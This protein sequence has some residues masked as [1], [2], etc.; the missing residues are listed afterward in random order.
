MLPRR[1]GKTLQVWRGE[2][3]A[4]AHL[5]LG[6]VQR[7]RARNPFGGQIT[8][9]RNTGCS[10][11]GR[12]DTACPVVPCLSEPPSP[13]QLPAA[14]ALRAPA[15]IYRRDGPRQGG[16]GPAGT[17]PSLHRDG[18]GRALR[19]VRPG[20]AGAWR[21]RSSGL[22]RRVPRRETPRW[23][24][25][26][27]GA[28]PESHGWSQPPRG[29]SDWPEKYWGHMPG[30]FFFFGYLILLVF[31]NSVPMSLVRLHG[32]CWRFWKRKGSS[33]AWWKVVEDGHEV[34]N[35]PAFKQ[36]EN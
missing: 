24:G 22:A 21:D 3:F 16:L 19:L 30:F 17:G 10:V 26:V 18:L 6:S 36:L 33:P 20:R 35:G 32:A 34:L 12:G 8:S 2:G 29:G 14:G 15:A 25:W 23:G 9:L 1:G 28:C 13:P 27:R 4:A 7:E 5:H 31:Q 11:P